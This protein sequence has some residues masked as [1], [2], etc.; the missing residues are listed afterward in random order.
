MCLFWGTTYLAIRIGL[1]G[2]PIGFLLG[3][4]Y[5]IA[6]GVLLLASRI[7][8][9]A[10]PRGRELWLTALCGIIGIGLGNGFLMMAELK[11]PS[12]LAALFYTTAPFWT[13]GMDAFLPRGKKPLMVTLVGLLVGV[14]GVAY[15]IYPDAVQEG[16]G[17]KTLPG[18]LLIQISVA[19]WVFGALM[20]KRV[21]SE[22]P[23]FVSGAVQQ[24][25]AGVASFVPALT[26]EKLPPAVGL[27]HTGGSLP[28]DFRF[29]HRLQRVHLFGEEVACGDCLGLLFCES[30]SGGVAR[31]DVLPR[32]IRL[33]RA[34]AMLI[35][36][37]GIALVR[38]SES[39]KRFSAAV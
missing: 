12:G 8:G 17:G 31:L 27:R 38:W 30:D 22:A 16:L 35:I 4:R 5:V 36:F 28:D 34:T 6:G 32:A 14:L 1:E 26:L 18:F 7:A 10:I 39:A 29:N 11:I 19:A 33:A 23:P 9:I 24:L 15:L 37:S 21:H 3:I 20:Q 2:L 25:A 13:V